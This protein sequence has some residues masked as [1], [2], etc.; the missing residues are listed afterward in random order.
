MVRK[1]WKSV[2]WPCA[3]RRGIG[4]SL[5]ELLV[6]ISIVV[7]I[8]SLL[9]PSL[10]NMVARAR[11]VNCMGNLRQISSAVRLY[12]SDNDNAFPPANAVANTGLGWSG[13]W[14]SPN[15]TNGG[16]VGY[17][18][19]QKE[20]DKLAVC[21]ENRGATNYQYCVNYYV[22]APNSTNQ[23][24]VKALKISRSAKIV[25]M[26][27][28]GTG[29]SWNPGSWGPSSGWAAITN[30]HGNYLN[31]LWVDGHVTADQRTNLSNTNF[32]P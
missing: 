26:A 28:S 1:T 6:A 7:I 17:V 12:M 4:F 2:D 5:I 21:P 19:G 3:L 13:Y 29:S 15:A 11:S 24:P 23:V 20:M 9:F 14:F 18:G 31:V 8:A 16:M 22:M 27:D 10:R 32:I 25:L 30:R